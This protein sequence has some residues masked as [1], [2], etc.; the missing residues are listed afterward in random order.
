MRLAPLHLTVDY[1]D[2]LTN[3]QNGLNRLTAALAEG[4][5]E[6]SIQIYNALNGE[7]A[8]VAVFLRVHTLMKCKNENMYLSQ[9]FEHVPPMK[10]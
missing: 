1:A 3:V 6:K 2:A 5:L 10:D 4:D 9:I 8:R 7:W